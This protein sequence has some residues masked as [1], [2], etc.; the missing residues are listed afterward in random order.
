MYE[1]TG[2]ITID[3]KNHLLR[4]TVLSAHCIVGHRV[5]PGIRE[6]VHTLAKVLALGV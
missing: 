6:L 1:C 5:F 2:R 4:G 3:F